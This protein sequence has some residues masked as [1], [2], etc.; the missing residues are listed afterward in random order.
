[1]LIIILIMLEKNM[2]IHTYT[3]TIKYHTLAAVSI[4]AYILKDS[5][6]SL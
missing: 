5:S 4:H 1:M 2:S 6:A 3:D